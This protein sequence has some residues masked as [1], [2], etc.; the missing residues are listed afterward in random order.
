M[1]A[2]EFRV[3]LQ[4]VVIVS[5]RGEYQRPIGSGFFLLRP[6]RLVTAKHVVC[7]DGAFRDNLTIVHPSEPRL[8]VHYVHTELD[9]AVLDV[10]PPLCRYPLAPSHERLVGAKGL[11][12]VGYSPSQSDKVAHRYVMQFNPISAYSRET[13]TRSADEDL[14]VFEAPYAEGGHSGGPV[15]GEGGTVVGVMIQSFMADGKTLM[16][17]TGVHPLVA[18]VDFLRTG[19]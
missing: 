14:V 13:R 4:S 9:L 12:C 3:D 1:T 11:V 7:I 17:A 2:L 5:V 8:S 19:D 10:D 6:D 15:L 18:D 16:R